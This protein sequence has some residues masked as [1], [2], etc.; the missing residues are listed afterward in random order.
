LPEHEQ[1][2]KSIR[3]GLTISPHKKLF[4]FAAVLISSGIDVL[5]AQVNPKDT[6]KNVSAD[7]ISVADEEEE[8]EQ[9][10][11]Y[12]AQDSVVSFPQLGKVMLYGKAKVDY[13]SMKMEAG[14]L[15]IDYER[16]LVKAYGRKDSLGLTQETPTFN[17]G[18][19]T[20]QADT[21][22]YN[23]KT[24][25]GKIYNALTRQG[26]FLVKGNEIKKDSN[27]IVY[28][29][30]M[31]CIPCQEEDARTVFRATKAKVIP[32]DKIIT[33]PMYLE[34]GGVPTPLG[35]PFGYFPNTKK[36]HNGV[37]LPTFGA[38]PGQGY[39]LKQGGFYWGINDQ[40]DMIIRTDLYANGSWGVNSTNNYN[41]L[42]KS[43]GHTFLSYSAF[44]LGDKDI[45]DTYSKQ[46]SY[47]VGW[48]HQ[49]DNKS[50]PSIRFSANVDFR[51]NQIFNR[52]NAVNSGQFLQN[53]FQ[54]NINFTRTFR[55]SSLSLNATHNQNSLTRQMDITLPS[56]TYNINRF[57]P[58]KRENAV[59]QNVLDKVQ[60]YY[61][62]EAR[63]TLS[64]RDSSIF[65]GSPLDSLRYGIRH[66]LPI[67]T[68]VNIFKYITATPAVNL[69]SVMF[70]RSIRKTYVQ[71]SDLEGKIQTKTV[72]D[73]VAGYDANFTTSF[74]TQV[75]FD[76]LF[77]RGSVKQIRHLMIPTLT[78]M[79]R[80]D[81]GDKQYGFWK[82]VPTDTLGGIT[83]YSI[84]ERSIYPGPAVGKQNSLSINLSNN[85]E[86]KFKKQTDTGVVYSKKVLLQNL[87]LNT[88][89][90][91]AADSFKMR[92]IGITARTVLFKYFDIVAS[93]SFDP[94]AYDKKNDRRLKELVYLNESRI[95]RFE[96]AGFT[97]NTSIGS[98]MLE[99]LKKTRQ[100]P[101]MTNGA[102]QGARKD[103]S[104]QEVLPWNLRISYNLGLSKPYDSRL[105]PV[106]TLNFSGDLMP[107]KYWTIGVTSGFDFT[108]Q[109]VSYTSFNIRRD[110]K[111]WEANIGW[112]P[113]GI[114]KQY[115]I[116]VHLKMSMLSEFKI[117]RQRQWYDNFQ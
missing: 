37:L 40:T 4:F 20:I 90:N 100:A 31:I 99:A 12:S 39:N 52:L 47:Q 45:P 38:S 43:T 76:Y 83:K 21:I 56:L 64:G 29:K 92:D 65:K 86:G 112:V 34:V 88:G 28:F 78:Y 59:R 116:A 41:V 74:N 115:N 9:P 108:T 103:V 42:Y 109:K 26:E 82:N 60:M 94:Y 13:G 46:R 18:G 77:S 110:L 49:Q 85:V 93:S 24:R 23:L 101:E 35:L 114:R 10:V 58:F 51:N 5:N 53:T 102:E 73:F 104:A 117:P 106:Q 68:N 32:D 48:M 54:S 27:N 63:N 57:F 71:Q 81:F 50:N 72:N 8:L 75:Y 113:F 66:S 11:T 14:I 7:T 15:E 96:G 80:P 36:K 87:S 67:S 84:F 6:L 79:Y 62:L 19:E 111:C 95:A 89:Y 22:K 70:T 44:N 107:T 1:L 2:N 98:N 30:N 33:G 25:R 16:S 105:Q 3:F 61:I 97:V 91:F 17:D 69:S 55:W